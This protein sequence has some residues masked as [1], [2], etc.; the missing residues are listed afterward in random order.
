MTIGDVEVDI[1]VDPGSVSNVIDRALWADLKM[2]RDKCI[3]RKCD[4]KLYL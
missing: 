2:E 4:K 1:I 3:S